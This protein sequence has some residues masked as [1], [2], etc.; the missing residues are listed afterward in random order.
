[1]GV[2]FEI[3]DERVSVCSVLRAANASEE[4]GIT[5]SMSYGSVGFPAG[6]DRGE[7][8]G[9]GGGGYGVGTVVLSCGRRR[10]KVTTIQ[11]GWGGGEGG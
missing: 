11:R 2:L 1:M 9:A 7:K 4:A 5:A 10:K 3:I 8:V 6:S